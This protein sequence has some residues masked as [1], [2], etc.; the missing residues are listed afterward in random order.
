MKNHF[1][2]LYIVFIILLS[3]I[4][5]CQNSS[6]NYLIG[7]PQL[8]S[9]NKIEQFK[10]IDFSVLFSEKYS[11]YNL[12]YIDE[13]YKRIRIKFISII[14]NPVDPNIYY[15]YG[16]SNVEGNICE[17]QGKFE[18]YKISILNSMHFGVDDKY[19]DEG[20]KLQGLIFVNYIF[21]EDP[22][23]G[24][25]GYFRGEGYSA[26]YMGKENQINFDDIESHS[27]RWCNNQFVGKWISYTT[28]QSKICNWGYARIPQSGDLDNGAGEF[29]PNE[30]YW[31]QG[32]KYSIEHGGNTLLQKKVKKQ[33]I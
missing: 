16:K 23:Q 18:I 5:L 29:A 20:I 15:V 22:K 21:Y 25:P 17:F 8:G 9:E 2:L 27:D 13:N 30:K 19:K 32:G 1:I 7:N 26:W 14:K 24:H 4:S 3:E 12:G 10:Y 28:N 6:H 31:D 33:K 11:A